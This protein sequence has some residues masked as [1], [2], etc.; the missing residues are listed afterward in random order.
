VRVEVCGVPS[1]TV[2]LH[3]ERGRVHQETLAFG[4]AGIV[5][6]PTT[7]AESGFARI[8]V[9]HDGGSMA[10]LSNPILLG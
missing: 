5:E 4:T 7:P 6:W 1:G 10:A 2:S 9:R 8:E 3:T